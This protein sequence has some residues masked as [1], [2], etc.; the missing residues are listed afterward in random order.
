MDISTPSDNEKKHTKINFPKIMTSQTF[1]IILHIDNFR[2]LSS[3]L[4]LQL[5]AFQWFKLGNIENDTQST[6]KVEDLGNQLR[7]WN[8]TFL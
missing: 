8:L 6:M 7:I 1:Y 5:N 2:R 3:C 4:R